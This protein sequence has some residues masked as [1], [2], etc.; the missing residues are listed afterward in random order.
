MTGFEEKMCIL[1][2]GCKKSNKSDQTQLHLTWLSA[3]A[4]SPKNFLVWLLWQFTEKLFYYHYTITEMKLNYRFNLNCF[5]WQ[6]KQ[7]ETHLFPQCIRRSNTATLKLLTHI[8]C[9]KQT[10][11]RKTAEKRLSKDRTYF[12]IKPFISALLLTRDISKSIIYNGNFKSLIFSF[13]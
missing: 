10:V 13:F 1:V 5:A 8:S 3:Y 2:T 12:S 7:S 11:V 9:L 6:E 4:I